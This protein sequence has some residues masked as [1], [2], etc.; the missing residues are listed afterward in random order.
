MQTR[1]IGTIIGAVAAAAAAAGIAV[2]SVPDGA[3]NIHACA[4]HGGELR[5]VDA[6]TGDACKSNELALQWNVIPLHGP[7]GPQGP[8]GPAGLQGPKGA[9]GVHGA[10]AVTYDE[11]TMTVF[12]V[13][14]GDPQIGGFSVSLTCPQGAKALWGGWTWFAYSGDKPPP[15]GESGPIADDEWLFAID[16]S[17]GS[18]GAVAS[19]ALS[20]AV[21]R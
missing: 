3:G 16:A 1:T 11:K 15:I 9:Q 21:T 18:K 10:N 19:L 13:G 8:P 5:I 7:A 14:V 20:C 2:A 6:D 4:K 12:G 17:S